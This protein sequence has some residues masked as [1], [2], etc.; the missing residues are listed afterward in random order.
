MKA[1]LIRGSEKKAKSVE[2]TDWSLRERSTVQCDSESE[3]PFTNIEGIKD[4]RESRMVDEVVRFTKDTRA[5][6]EELK[7]S[8]I[9][10]VQK[11]GK[12]D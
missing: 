6:V 9:R 8:P 11:S 2:G 10:N 7:N 1:V 12:E 4:M 3:Y 5:E